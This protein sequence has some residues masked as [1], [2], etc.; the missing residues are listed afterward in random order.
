MCLGR[1]ALVC[2]P[3]GKA[4]SRGLKQIPITSA[5]RKLCKK[6]FGASEGRGGVVQGVRVDAT[7]GC[8]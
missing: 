6:L 7:A 2:K 5:L 3:H 1:G 4:T 8:P